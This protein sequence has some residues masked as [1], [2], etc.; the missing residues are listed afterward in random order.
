M[1]EALIE[2][3]EARAKEDDACAGNSRAV[4]D[5][6]SPE[7]AKFNDRDA[8]GWNTYAVR[9]ALDHRKSMERDRRYAQDI[10]AAIAILRKVSNA[11]THPN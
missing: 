5:L 7:L 10:R 4:A 2:R 11:P 8:S 9:M 1:I 3:L 6:L